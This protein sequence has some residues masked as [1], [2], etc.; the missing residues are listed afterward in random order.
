M[1]IVTL[2]E[3]NVKPGDVVANSHERLF[4][5]TKVVGGKVYAMVQSE[6]YEARIVS[7]APYRIISRAE[8]QVPVR[9]LTR[10]EIVPGVYG[11]I[12]IGYTHPDPA[13]CIRFADQ[14]D[15]AGVLL[16]PE[17]LRA[18]AITMNEIADALEGKE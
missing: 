14:D 16:T 2:K 4:K 1:S 18:A 12:V 5:V 10:K 7:N 8:H 3:L 17:E 15:D 13:I 11:S 9:T 6:E